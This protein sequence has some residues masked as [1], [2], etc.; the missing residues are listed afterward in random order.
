MKILI[1]GIGVL[2]SACGD[3]PGRTPDSVATIQGCYEAPQGF[4]CNVIFDDGQRGTTV[5]TGWQGSYICK[6]AS[7][8]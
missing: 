2:L 5:T 7:L 4:T 8:P 3:G 1:L 6:G